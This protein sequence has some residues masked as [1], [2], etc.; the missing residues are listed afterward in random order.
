MCFL[1]TNWTN[2]KDQLLRINAQNNFKKLWSNLND[3]FSFQHGEN[4]SFKKLKKFYLKFS[5]C[6][7]GPNRVKKYSTVELSCAC[8]E[9]SD[10]LKNLSNQ[11]EYYSQYKIIL[12]Y[13]SLKNLALDSDVFGLESKSLN[14]RFNE[15]PCEYSYLSMYRLICKQVVYG[16]TYYVPSLSSRV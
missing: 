8:F 4:L 1:Q 7:P 15:C 16:C 5:L 6:T 13:F 14:L 9:N 2:S 3:F 10:W 11:S 12:S